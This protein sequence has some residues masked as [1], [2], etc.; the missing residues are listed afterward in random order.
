MEVARWLHGTISIEIERQNL[1]ER[2]YN[3]GEIYRVLE[4]KY[5]VHQRK[6]TIYCL[7]C[8]EAVEMVLNSTK[9][10]YFRHPK[11]SVCPAKDNYRTYTNSR[12]MEN[13]KKFRVGK[14]IIKTYLEGA[15]T[16]RGGRVI[17][18]YTYSRKLKHIPDLVVIL[19]DGREI[20]IDYV[21]GLK[22]ND[23]YVNHVVRRIIGY[24]EYGFI[25]YFF[26]DKNWLSIKDQY[27]SIC[28]AEALIRRKT[29]SDLQW[30]GFL[31]NLRILPEG[32]YL[33]SMINYELHPY[34]FY[35]LTYV[36][37]ENKKGWVARHIPIPGSS[38]GY[39]AAFP[40]AIPFEQLFRV[41]D[42]LLLQLGGN[43]ERIHQ[44]DFHA[45][46]ILFT[47]E[48]EK[49]RIEKMR[50][51]QKQQQETKRKSANHPKVT[52]KTAPQKSHFPRIVSPVVDTVDI[53][54][55]EQIKRDDERRMQ[56]LNAGYNPDRW[57]DK[58]RFPTQPVISEDNATKKKKKLMEKLTS[59][60][61]QGDSYLSP[62]GVW[63]VE[64]FNLFLENPQITTEQAMIELKKRGI[65]FN[66]KESIVAYTIADTI[67]FIQ[68]NWK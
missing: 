45:K 50:T 16:H 37:V 3:W 9:V 36:D 41:D 8:G 26:I 25:P 23:Y 1:Q 35:S 14:Q 53:R 15:Y 32:K 49:K 43:D 61:I 51:L 56:R 31:T 54:T 4:E 68:R 24:Q 52:T 30:Q 7:C 57:T 27:L 46:L 17:D 64:I 60:Q 62:S 38:W 12:D 19:P 34:D 44:D 42:S 63:R 29:E 13:D 5:R 21:T 22:N 55:P 6:G 40:A 59:K 66:Q 39:V 20:C 11:D 48:E 18:G 28:K 67:A 65:K 33:K 58:R 10:C 2:G 47:A